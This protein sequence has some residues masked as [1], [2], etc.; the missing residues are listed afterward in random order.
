[1]KATLSTSV[2]V[3]SILPIE[4]GPVIT[5]STPGGNPASA[6]TSAN[7]RALSRVYVAGFK[8]TVLPIA[9]AGHTFH[10]INI[11]GKFHGTMAPTTPVQTEAKLI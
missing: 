2:C 6:Q 4:P 5:F 9:S 1:M 10:S 7:S 3:A 11:S 8:T